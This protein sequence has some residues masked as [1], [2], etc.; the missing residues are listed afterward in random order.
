MYEETPLYPFDLGQK[1]EIRKRETR[2]IQ[3]YHLADPLV[4]YFGIYFRSPKHFPQNVR[5]LA[6]K[7]QGGFQD[8]RFQLF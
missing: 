6:Q 1:H 7:T 2:T 4:K 3:I 5:T 8:F